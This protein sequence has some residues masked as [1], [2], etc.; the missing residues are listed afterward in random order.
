MNV[1]VVKWTFTDVCLTASHHIICCFRPQLFQGFSS[2]AGVAG[3][4][5][6]AE[7]LEYHS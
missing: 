1:A 6:N 5:F 4:L 2:V 7:V 3:V